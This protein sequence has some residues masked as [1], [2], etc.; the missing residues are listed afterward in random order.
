VSSS[1]DLVADE[2]YCAAKSRRW[3]YEGLSSPQQHRCHLSIS[4]PDAVLAS[5][6]EYVD[7]RAYLRLI[8]RRADF[9]ALAPPD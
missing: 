4:H 5:C 2:Y 1:L 7:N 9:V 3:R 6:V 8:M